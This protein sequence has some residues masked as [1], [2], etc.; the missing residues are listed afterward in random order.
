[1]KATGGGLIVLLA[2][3]LSIPSPALS[4][5]SFADLHPPGWVESRAACVNG[6]GEV[7]GYGVTGSGERGFLWSDGVFTEIV[8]PGADGARASWVNGRGDVAGT[9]VTGGRFQA[10]LYRNGTY[11][12]PTPGWAYSE[13]VYVAE[14]GAVTGRGEFGAYISRDGVTELLPEFTAVVAVNAAGQLLG[15]AENTAMLYLPGKGFLALSPPKA[16]R[17]VPHGL[18]ESGLVAISSIQDG[19]ETGFVYSGGFYVFMVPSG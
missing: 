3:F 13:A 1:M 16:S 18:N 17:V 11:Q 2:V 19:S 14:D 9:A 10:F 4:S 5:Y 7:A 15:T 12:D 8:P 6:R